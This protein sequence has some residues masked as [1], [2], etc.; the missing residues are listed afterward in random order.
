MPR[1]AAL[2]LRTSDPNGATREDKHG[3]TAQE[4]EC[5]QY[6]GRAGLTVVAVYS[7]AISGTTEARTGFG[8]LLADAHRFTDLVVYAVDRLAR[9]PRAGYALIE[10]AHL[11]G[12][13]IHTAIEGMVDLDDD[14]GAMNTGMR[15]VFAD[16]ERR[17]VVK[18][19]AAGKVAKMR[20]GKTVFKLRKYGWKDDQVQ[21][22]E[23]AWVTWMF[24]RALEVGAHTIQQEL[25]AQGVPSP[26]GEAAWDTS[27]IQAI[28]RDPAYRGE[29][30]WG[31]SKPGRPSSFQAPISAPCPRIVSDELWW[32][33]QRAMQAR[34]KGQGRRSSRADLFALQGRITCAECGRAMIGHRRDER[35]AYYTCGDSRHP[36][37]KRHGC[38]HRVYYPAE[39][40]HTEVRGWLE[41][42]LGQDVDLT[43]YLPNAA[44]EARDVTP[45]LS[46]IDVR[47]RRVKEAYEAGIDSLQEYGE[48]KARLEAQRQAIL[49]APAPAAPTV[50][51]DAARQV[52][53]DALGLEFRGA[54]LKLGLRVQV[55]NGGGLSVS[56]DPVI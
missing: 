36:L 23:A 54:A 56:L 2:Y 27:L 38:T 52:L 51:P 9:H 39:R 29:W 49:N 53:R 40:I 17:R 32:A 37:A 35:N 14:A 10:T 26:T 22:A 50:S 3:L 18:R 19:L 24:E 16:A 43:P 13:T 15:L 44:P 31:R 47:L 6:A 34:R 4:A 5:R 7:D 33:V 45:L 12:L 48:K 20:A 41:G 25:H 55:R 30:L 21:P 11:A 8:Q 1:P 42:L 28:L 46:D